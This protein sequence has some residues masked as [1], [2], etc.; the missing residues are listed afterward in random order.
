[1]PAAS[2]GPAATPGTPK[3]RPRSSR[4]LLPSA[5][6]RGPLDKAAGLGRRPSARSPSRRRGPRAARQ[7]RTA[8]G[9]R[10]WKSPPWAAGEARSPGGF[11]RPGGKSLTS[12]LTPAGPGP[13]SAPPRSYLGEREGGE[14]ER[15][16]RLPSR[17]PG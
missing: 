17:P 9:P 2:E 16:S 6:V 8:P 4:C 15:R 7:P 13:P 12:L 14:A 3:G 10:G 11:P 5:P 1:M